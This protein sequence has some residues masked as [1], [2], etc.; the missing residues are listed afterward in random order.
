[1]ILP[2]S[3]AACDLFQDAKDTIDGITD[4]LVAQ[5]VILGVDT[6]DVDPELLEA[7]DFETGVAVSVFLADAKSV[8]DIDNAPIGG[9]SVHVN[10]AL[11]PEVG[12][13]AYLLESNEMQYTAGQ[14][15]TMHALIAGDGS[16]GSVVLPPPINVTVPETHNANTPM[17]LTITNQD[18]HAVVGLVVEVE[19]GEVTWSNEPE[20]IRDVYDLATGSGDT[21]ALLIPAEA[22]PRVGGYVIGITGLERGEG[23]TLDNMNTALSAI[24]AGK[25]RLLPTAALP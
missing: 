22:F 4:P 13:G 20:D 19:S 10:E 24:M 23:E 3:I 5:A 7:A 8:N 9:A 17:N 15:W 14:S 6:S 11:V 21:S 25:M 12:D 16:S 2:M 1:M 18:F